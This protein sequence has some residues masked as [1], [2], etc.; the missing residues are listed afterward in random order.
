MNNDCCVSVRSQAIS[1]DLHTI[2]LPSRKYRTAFLVRRS[3]DCVETIIG[4]RCCWRFRPHF[5]AGAESVRILAGRARLRLGSICR[6]VEAGEAIVVPAGVVHRFEP[7]DQEGWAFCSDFVSNSRSA[8]VTQIESFE[9]QKQLGMQ[10]RQ[11]LAGR[12]SLHT[13]VEAIAA[14]CHVSAGYLSRTFR[15]EMGTSLHN[16]HVLIA[17]HRAKTLLR[18][19]L[20]V[21]DAALDAGFYD[22][23]H[24]TREFVRTFG[25]TPG[26]FRSAWIAAS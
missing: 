26:T 11:Q 8:E 9:T 10:A 13:D 6:E 23:A 20:P 17:I 3:S 2:C 21:A 18:N 5:H 14:R 19:H 22:Q 24:L 12:R 4:K 1:G 15:R 16:F 25:M 7:L